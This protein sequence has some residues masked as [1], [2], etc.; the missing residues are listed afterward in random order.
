MKK[1]LQCWTVVQ[2][3]KLKGIGKVVESKDI[4]HF[5]PLIEIIIHDRLKKKYHNNYP[6]HHLKV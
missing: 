3:T 6:H 4:Y 1:E 2:T 5:I